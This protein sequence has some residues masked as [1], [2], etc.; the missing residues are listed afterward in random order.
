MTMNRR[1]AL[2]R[3][4]TLSVAGGYCAGSAWADMAAK[5]TLDTSHLIYLT[6]YR[7]DGSE[8]ACHGEVWFVHHEQEIYVVTKADAWRANAIRQ[9][10]D[11]AKIWIGEFGMWKSSNDAY[12]A[13]PSLDINGAIE[14]D[15][16]VHA[17][18]LDAFGKKYAK[19]WG[20]WGPRFRD[21][22][23]EGSRVML[24]YQPA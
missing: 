13:A 1:H 6:P 5:P 21:G 8:S 11:K 7:S 17:R 3:V 12:R 18:I 4:I 16:R 15:T 23:D 10:L 2:K 24:R 19:E 9:K 14:A 22:L 20:V